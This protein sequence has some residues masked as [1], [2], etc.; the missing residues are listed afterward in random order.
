MH[1]EAV[2][3]S[4]RQRYRQSV[5]EYREAAKKP[6][7]AQPERSNLTQ[8][9]LGRSGLDIEGMGLEE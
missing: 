4:I 7:P 6:G 3:A 5:G 1:D 8:R 9:N 2:L